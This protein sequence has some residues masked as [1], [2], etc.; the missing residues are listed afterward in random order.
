MFHVVK[1]WITFK[2]QFVILYEYIVL[3]ARKNILTEKIAYG[4]SETVL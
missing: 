4:Q 2:K 1:F 3:W